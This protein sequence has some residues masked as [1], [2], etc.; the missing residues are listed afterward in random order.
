MEHNSITFLNFS[1]LPLLFRCLHFL[2]YP[3]PTFA[4]L[5]GAPGD[6]VTLRAKDYCIDLRA[7]TGGAPVVVENLAREHLY[8]F[9][10]P[11]PPTF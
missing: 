1:H 4:V 3:S 11:T 7:A 5:L 2:A 6:R 10:P 8:F 9:E